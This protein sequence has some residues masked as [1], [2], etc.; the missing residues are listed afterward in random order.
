MLKIEN[1]I[2]SVNRGDDNQSF[3]FSISA[4]EEDYTFQV[5]DKIRFGV[6]NKKQLD[7]EAIL[8]KEITVAEETNK[9]T[10]AFTKE[11]LTIGDLINKPVDY[12]YEIQ[13]NDNTIIG[14][15]KDGAKIFRLY[16]EGSDL[17]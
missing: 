2:I 5:G 15:D 16:P 6:Y 3:E 7:K 8:L 17:E 12:W 11:E 9:V 1:K 4:G 10:I 14:Y 13:L